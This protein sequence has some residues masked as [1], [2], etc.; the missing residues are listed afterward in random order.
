MIHCQVIHLE[1]MEKLIN[2]HRVR[3]T[4]LLPLW[5]IAG[6]CNFCYT[7]LS[8]QQLVRFALGAG[9]ALLGKEAA[10]ACTVAVEEVISEHYND[11]IRFVLITLIVL[12]SAYESLSELYRHD[13]EDLVEIRKVF[14]RFRDEELEHRDIGIDNNAEQV[15]IHEQA[16]SGRYSHLCRLLR[17]NSCRS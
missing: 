15:E 11:Q 12:L 10:M 1:V 14:R 17:T 16:R 8:P 5:K 6:Y 9:T 3:P 4:A 7:F 13:N 2:E